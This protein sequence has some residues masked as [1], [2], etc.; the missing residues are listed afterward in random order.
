MTGQTLRQLA[1]EG[2]GILSSAGVPDAKL[3]TDLYAKPHQ[4]ADNR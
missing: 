1:A 2:T 4:I 3:E